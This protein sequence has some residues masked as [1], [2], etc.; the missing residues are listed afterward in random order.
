MGCTACVALLWGRQ[1]L[2]ANAGDCRAVLLRDDSVGGDAVISSG[3]DHSDSAHFAVPTPHV[4]SRDHTA[5]D[6]GERGRVAVRGAG[7]GGRE[8]LCQLQW[9]Y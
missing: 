5:A 6:A 4:L 8:K 3:A 7:R 1:L 2:V 9:A